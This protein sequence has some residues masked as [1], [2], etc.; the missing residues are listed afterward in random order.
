MVTDCIVREYKLYG[1]ETASI[2]Q[3]MTALLNDGYKTTLHYAA[4]SVGHVLLEA[5]KEQKE[6]E[7]PK[8][9]S[10]ATKKET[11]AE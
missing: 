2:E 7:K 8:A 3:D 1:K 6:A 4:D 9:K 11:T 5:V 10:K